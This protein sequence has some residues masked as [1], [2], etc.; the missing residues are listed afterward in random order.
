[1]ERNLVRRG[2]ITAAQAARLRSM[3]TIARERGVLDVGPA[4]PEAE[5]GA[6]KRRR[7][8]VT[9]TEPSCDRGRGSRDRSR[10]CPRT[11]PVFCRPRGGRGIA[12]AHQLR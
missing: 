11:T 9:S 6:Q 4:T 10:T 5:R 3:S 8:G 2:G 12:T 7:P 1:V